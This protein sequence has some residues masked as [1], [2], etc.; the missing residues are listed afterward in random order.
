[1]VGAWGLMGVVGPAARSFFSPTTTH[2]PRHKLLPSPLY[3]VGQLR[4]GGHNNTIPLRKRRVA[5]SVPLTLSIYLSI[6]ISIYL[7]SSLSRMRFLEEVHTEG[8]NSTQYGEALQ[9]FGSRRST[10]ANSAGSE[11]GSR[12]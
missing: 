1:M 11:T 10:S 3:I 4:E 7:S 12:R 9:G 8:V 6:Y 5:L 2:F